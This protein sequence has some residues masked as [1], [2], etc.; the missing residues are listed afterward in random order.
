MHGAFAAAIERTVLRKLILGLLLAGLAAC[1]P[2]KAPEPAVTTPVR[3]RNVMISSVVMF[4]P[5]RFAGTWYVAQSA[6]PGCAGN[7]QVWKWTGRGYDVSGTDCGGS[8]AAGVSEHVALTG[9]GGR[10][11]P[12]RSYSGEKIWLL[13]ADDGYRVA[14]LGTPS[15]KFGVIL[16]RTMPP[17]ADLVTAARRVLDFNGYDLRRIGR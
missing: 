2:K 5:A 16:T 11:M 9:P 17:K 6:V 8:R 3:D 10:F 7:R 13:W 1:A 4:D 14:T 12:S 15:G